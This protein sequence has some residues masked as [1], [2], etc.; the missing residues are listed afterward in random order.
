MSLA[1]GLAKARDLK[2]DRENI[3]AVIGDGSLSGGEAYEGLSNAGET[4]TNLIVVVNDNEM[5]I[6]EN[7]GGLYQNLK[8]LRDSD[9]KRLAIFSS[10]SGLITST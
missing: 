2:G 10:L 4:G 5:S 7:H 8:A 1:C 6:A 9:G 3:I